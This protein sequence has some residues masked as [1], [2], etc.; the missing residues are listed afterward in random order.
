MRLPMWPPCREWVEGDNLQ[1]RQIARAAS[2]TV[3]LAG[4]RPAEAVDMAWE[5]LHTQALGLSR[6]TFRVAW[7]TAVEACLALGQIDE[8]DRLLDMVGSSPPGHVPPYLRAQL[9]RFR[10]LRSAG[11]G[12]EAVEADFRSAVAGMTSLRYPYWLARSQLDLATWLTDQARDE[13]ADQL[14]T[15]A[16]AVLAGLNVRQPGDP[17]PALGGTTTTAG[18]RP[19][20]S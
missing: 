6:E 18:G 17:S 4:G 2:A 9:A 16:R 8:A 14:S 20:L 7:P 19:V 12:A 11:T 3:F 5:S 1:D 10:A 13:E 15:T